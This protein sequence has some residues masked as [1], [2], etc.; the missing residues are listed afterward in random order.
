MTQNA[1][2]VKHVFNLTKIFITS[3]V[4]FII[5]WYNDRVANHPLESIIERMYSSPTKTEP[6][7]MAQDKIV[8]FAPRSAP[9][10]DD[11][12]RFPGVMPGVVCF[13]WFRSTHRPKPV[14]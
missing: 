8:V 11:Y 1:S 10:S 13:R 6:K 9:V 12:M 4:A 7:I 5:N 14:F 3:N 2:S